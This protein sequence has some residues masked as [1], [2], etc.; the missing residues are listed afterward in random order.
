LSF[1][2]GARRTDDYS[3]NM[4]RDRR[5]LR[6]WAAQMLLVWLFGVATGVAHACALR[7]ADHPADA[8]FVPPAGQ[9]VGAYQGHGEPSPGGDGQADCLDFC[10]KSSV[11]APSPKLKADPGGDPQPVAIPA[12]PPVWMA[13]GSP[14]SPARPAGTIDPR[15]GPPP[16][17]AFQR[18][19]L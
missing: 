13:A 3:E 6:R 4:L 14:C 15:G 18:L 7:L 9:A 12:R 17:I 11:T 16:R 1:V 5:R 8:V 2:K 19:A 10:E